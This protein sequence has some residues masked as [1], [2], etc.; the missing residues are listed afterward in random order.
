MITTLPEIHLAGQRPLARRRTHTRSAY[1]REGNAHSRPVPSEKGP[2]GLFHLTT[3]TRSH[4][5]DWFQPLNRS[6]SRKR[7]SSRLAKPPTHKRYRGVYAVHR[8][9]LTL[10]SCSCPLTSNRRHVRVRG[11][12]AQQISCCQETTDQSP[13]RRLG[14]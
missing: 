12:N 9:E 6:W 7:S 10:P 8:R 1:Y 11:A 13:R 3:C 4:L 5:Q 14:S 2:M